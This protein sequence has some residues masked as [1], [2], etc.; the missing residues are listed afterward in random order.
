MKNKSNSWNFKTIRD[1]RVLPTLSLSAGYNY[2]AGSTNALGAKSDGV[3]G[4]IFHLLN[5]K[6][7]IFPDLRLDL[8]LDK[9]I[10]N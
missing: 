9:Q 7:P 4:L 1:C 10:F 5:L 2:M 3:F 8:K 6:I